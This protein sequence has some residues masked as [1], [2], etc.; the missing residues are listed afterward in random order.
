MNQ[1]RAY[2]FG[3]AAVSDQVEEWSSVLQIRKAPH[4]SR[5]TQDVAGADIPMHVSCAEHVK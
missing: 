2:R 4:T 1:A 3:T 5:E